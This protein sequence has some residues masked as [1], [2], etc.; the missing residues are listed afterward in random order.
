MPHCAAEND[1]Q[2]KFLLICENL[3]K[4]RWLDGLDSIRIPAAASDGANAMKP[5]SKQ[6]ARP[7]VRAKNATAVVE[8]TS[9]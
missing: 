2:R 6:F 1:F 5:V 4:R 7:P 8:E 3:F 9:R